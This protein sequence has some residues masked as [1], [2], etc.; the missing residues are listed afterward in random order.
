MIRKTSKA[1]MKKVRSLRKAGATNIPKGLYFVAPDNKA[2]VA[3]N[4]KEMTEFN[5]K[6]KEELTSQLEFI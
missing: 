4:L 1:E 2:Y 3:D 5:K 6:K